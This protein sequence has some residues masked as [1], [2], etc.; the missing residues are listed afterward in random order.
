MG[1]RYAG[2]LGN[3]LKPI[4]TTGSTHFDTVCPLNALIMYVL[5][6][7][8]TVISIAYTCWCTCKL[9]LHV[10][11]FQYRLIR[12]MYVMRKAWIHD[13]PWIALHKP[14]I[15]ALRRQPMDFP[16]PNMII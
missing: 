6:I 1:Y 15:H 5:I 9:W 11:Q 3:Y 13:N 12:N 16:R 4:D 8:C 10:T 2:L 7:M 14:W